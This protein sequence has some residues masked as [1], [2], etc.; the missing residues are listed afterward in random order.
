MSEH[1]Y[2]VSVVWKEGRIGTMSSP[3][4][5][6]KIEVAT[7]PEF[8]QGVPRIWSPEHLYAAAINSCF[9]TTFLAIAEN[10]Q[11]EYKHFESK[12]VC[13]LEKVEKGFQITKAEI[14][15]KVELLYPEKD[16]ER[17][18]RILEKSEKVCLISNSI[19]TE[20]TLKLNN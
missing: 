7:P 3:V 11:L 6:D 15:P 1:K 4:L 17:L 2:E 16:N 8:P 12:T 5:D 20:V 19:K 10:S 18:I 13:T 14:E 9:M